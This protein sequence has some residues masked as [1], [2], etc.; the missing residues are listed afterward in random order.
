MTQSYKEIAAQTDALYSPVSDTTQKIKVR[1]D[2]L[3]YQV[4][5]HGVD[6]APTIRALIESHDMRHGLEQ[7]YEDLKRGPLRSEVLVEVGEN[8]A[9]VS[10]KRDRIY[11][12]ILPPE[13]GAPQ[14]VKDTAPATVKDE[15]GGITLRIPGVDTKETKHV[16]PGDPVL[17]N[18][19]AGVIVYPDIAATKIGEVARIDEITQQ[20]QVIVAKGES[21]FQADVTHELRGQL[22]EGD[23]VVLDEQRLF[24]H[25][26]IK[27]N[28]TGE[29]LLVPVEDF[30][31]I[32]PDDIGA[33]HPEFD[34]LLSRIRQVTEHPEWCEKMNSQPSASY[35][36]C[37]PTGTGKTLH[38]KLAA[39]Q[40][41]E[42]AKSLCGD[43]VSCL[44][45]VDASSFYSP[46]FG[47]TEQKIARFFQK[48]RALG[49]RSVST[50]KNG[51]VTLPLL[52]VLEE[53]EALLRT[54]SSSESSSH[55]FDRPLALL[56]SKMSSVG[57]EMKMPIIFIATTNRPDMI[58]PAARRRFGRHIMHFGHLG[59]NEAESVLRKRIPETMP[60]CD[61][62]HDVFIGELLSYMYDE[63]G[64]VAV[65]TTQ[66]TRGEKPIRRGDFI[67]GAI[68]DGAISAATD[69]CLR[70]SSKRGKLIGLRSADVLHAID[71]QVEGVVHSLRP[72][73]M[74]EHVPH[75]C[76]DGKFLSVK[77]IQKDNAQEEAFVE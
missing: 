41:S 2:T 59:P 11:C 13:P 47:E 44:V 19:A 33:I 69:R 35:M 70:E 54:R 56:L 73:N 18:P 49:K 14:E 67:T 46:W 3:I 37:G 53:A 74:I 24:V 55:L 68:I 5:Q 51:E 22:K 50:K 40:I 28:D 66:N 57:E 15:D 7:F 31:D 21:R 61:A 29:E 58:D 9:I 71:T 8:Y 6:H 34:D 48:L 1:A 45:S 27:S 36:F 52:V 20:G 26:V 64:I 72:N 43:D 75:L 39:Q 62:K 63:N 60:L 32:N 4:V 30:I 23:R 12:A 16:T 77:P 10:D 25:E 38:A 65:A 42:Y 76:N 17:I